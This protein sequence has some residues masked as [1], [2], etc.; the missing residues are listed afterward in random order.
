MKEIVWDQVFQAASTL[1]AVQRVLS[2]LRLELPIQSLVVYAL[3]RSQRAA[4]V[5]AA[6]THGPFP[7]D[8]RTVRCTESKWSEMEAWVEENGILRQHGPRRTGKLAYLT[9]DSTTGS[10][11]GI[12]LRSFHADGC[13]QVG[14]AILEVEHG[15]ALRDEQWLALERLRG[16]LWFLL[17]A[18]TPRLSHASEAI[19]PEEGP[20]ATKDLIVG[21][22]S[23]LRSV[24]ERVEIVAPSDMPV[25][26]LGDTGTGKEVVAR[27]IH[28]RS[29][30]AGRPFIR[31]N[32]G[33]IPPELIDSQLFGH[34]RGSF[35]GASDQRKGWFERADGG[36][37]FLDEIG[38]L[39][40]AA[41]VRL[42]RVLQEHQ[43]ERV[44]GEEWIHVDVRIV[45][46]THRDLAGMVHQRSFRE[47]LWY[48]INMFPI[49]LPRLCERIEDIPALARHFAKRASTNFGL[50]YVELASSDIKQ[51][52][53]YRWPGNIRELQAVM[54]RAVILGR[55]SKLDI[56]NALGIGIATRYEPAVETDEPTFYEVIP[57]QPV[58]RVAVANEGHRVGLEKEPEREL[59]ALD[60]AIRRHIEKALV[61]TQGQIEGKRGAAHYLKI[62]PHTLRAKMRKLGI[63]WNQFREST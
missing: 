52:I 27:A 30:R 63:D 31:V 37:L 54:D 33:A 38:E 9:P 46:A 3:E 59:D 61:L 16:P 1:E 17:L 48:R 7:I 18:A 4:T 53:E 47:D 49:L 21:A 58:Q 28:Q 24:M 23:G 34:E 32:C 56:E 39:P 11:L 13:D 19:G 44:G 43:I 25:L 55:G 35:T 57:E 14:V 60:N 45:A 40:L 42:L 50:P 41:Q 15:R 36:T 5:V 62:N 20:S 29:S 8:A 12:P 2:N 51:L 26:I 22:D 10:A 6:A